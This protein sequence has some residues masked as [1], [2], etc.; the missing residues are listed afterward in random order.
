MVQTA[1]SSLFKAPVE[2]IDKPELDGFNTERVHHFFEGDLVIGIQ[3]I[4]AP[5]IV[6]KIQR[7]WMSAMD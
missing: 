6:L 2:L 7:Y 5:Q 4:G 3:D 1:F